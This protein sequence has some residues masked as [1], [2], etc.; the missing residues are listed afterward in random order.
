MNT[1]S[2][3]QVFSPIPFVQYHPDIIKYNE[4]SKSVDFDILHNHGHYDKH[5]FDSVSFYAKDYVKGIYKY[6]KIC[7]LKFLSSKIYTFV[8]FF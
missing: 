4:K 8:H 7:Y 1:I 5:N 2:Q 3:W 6:I